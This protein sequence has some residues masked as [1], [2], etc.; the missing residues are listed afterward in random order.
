MDAEQADEGLQDTV[1]DLLTR[2]Q[3]GDEDARRDLFDALYPTLRISAE[4]RMRDHPA[5]HTL[6]ATALVNEAFIR[7]VKPAKGTYRD[8]EHFLCAASQAMRHILVDHAR[9][10]AAQKRDGVKVHVD[11]CDVPAPD[12]RLDLPIANLESAL[13]KLETVDSQMARAVEMRFFAGASA[14]ETASVLSIAPRTFTARWATTMKW[15]HGKM[16]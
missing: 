1:S 8:R 15:L 11:L 2:L 7:L 13:L 14:A 6:Q 9:K 12:E 16:Q 3:Q 10:H 5:S 4:A